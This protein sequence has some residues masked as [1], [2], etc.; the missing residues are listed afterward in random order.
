[1]H[2]L[3]GDL[4]AF[5]DRLNCTLMIPCDILGTCLLGFTKPLQESV[6]FWMHSSGLEPS[7]AWLGRSVHSGRATKKNVFVK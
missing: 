2:S 6:S 1:M 5:P 4:V 7:A 3:A